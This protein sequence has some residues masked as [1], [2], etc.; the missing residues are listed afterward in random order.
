MP[1]IHLSIDIAAPVS[2]VWRA[3]CDPT[4]V[5]QW[6][7]SVEAAIDAPSDYP[8]SGQHVQWR[9][10][11]GIF[12]TLHDRPIEVVAEKT[13]RSDLKQGFIRH[14]E[15]YTLTPENGG[16]R[17]DV[18]LD[19]L[20]EAPFPLSLLISHLQAVANARLAFQ[21]SLQNIKHHCEA[22]ATTY[23]I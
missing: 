18:D 12:R 21:E 4:E 22:D 1:D 10:R 9:C 7:S 20:I 17:L 16:T 23:R 8:Q 6:D 13:L 2:R 3:L 5:A 15:T 11:S 19:V 14:D